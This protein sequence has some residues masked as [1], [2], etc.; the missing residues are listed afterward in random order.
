[1][2]LNKPVR[3]R[4]SEPGNQWDWISTTGNDIDNTNTIISV[5]VMCQLS[6]GRILWAQGSNIYKSDDNGHSWSMHAANLTYGEGASLVINALISTNAGL[7]AIMQHGTF[8]TTLLLSIDSGLTWTVVNDEDLVPNEGYVTGARTEYAFIEKDGIHF[9]TMRRQ[10]RKSNSSSWDNNAR[11]Y[12]FLYF[13]GSTWHYIGCDDNEFHD[14]G[15]C[16]TPSG[17]F[18]YG[19]ISN[20]TSGGM[21]YFP[22]VTNMFSNIFSN[23]QQRVTIY[24][25]DGNTYTYEMGA[26]YP[27]D[28]TYFI[29]RNPNA[30]LKYTIWKGDW[31]SNDDGITWQEATTMSYDQ[32]WTDELGHGVSPGYRPSNIVCQTTTGRLL[33]IG[34]GAAGITYS[35]DYGFSWLPIT[36]SLFENSH[37]Y[38]G[39]INVIGYPDYIKTGAPN[40][41]I[42]T[43]DDVVLVC[44]GFSYQD[45][46]NIDIRV[47]FYS[48]PTYTTDYV[49]MYDSIP[50]TGKEVKEYVRQFKAYV[51]SLKT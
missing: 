13:D 4:T 6:S 49:D 8:D 35:D 41:L 39:L 7:Y 29:V 44:Y 15:F 12:Y 3:R 30:P 36:N 48:E 37:D 42:L 34:G 16:V 5:P 18:I 21:W 2:K 45:N 43:K 14:G 50:V 11:Y 27:S 22:S 23:N 10:Y 19:T 17:K 32:G 38:P 20:V 31:Y 28:G 24:E 51:Q 25:Y 47:L 9:M 1:M 46:G 26:N 33:A 40:I